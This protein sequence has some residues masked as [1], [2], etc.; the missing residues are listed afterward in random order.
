LAALDSQKAC[1]GAAQRAVQ[2]MAKPQPIVVEFTKA[3]HGSIVTQRMIQRM[4]EK[5]VDPGSILEK[6]LSMFSRGWVAEKDSRTGLPQVKEMLLVGRLDLEILMGILA[7]FVKEPPASPKL[8]ETWKNTLKGHLGDDIDLQKPIAELIENRL[9]LPIRMKI[10]QKTLDEVAAVPPE[11]IVKAYKRLSDDLRR[12][13]AIAG[14][15]ELIQKV[16]EDGKI[17]W[18]QGAERKYWWPG[19]ETEYAWI[20]LECLP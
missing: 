1:S 3:C 2:E 15:R 19:K 14:E 6:G 5:G 18:A 4:R 13:R 8:I 7:G 12:L 20:P 17:E 16:T 11:G 9:G 10:L